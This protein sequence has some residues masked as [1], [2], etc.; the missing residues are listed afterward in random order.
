MAELVTVSATLAIDATEVTRAQY[1]A[2]LATQP[3]LGGQRTACEWNQSYVPDAACM[4]SSSVCQGA[5]CSR[6]PQPC[7]DFCDA[8]AYCE[9]VGKRLCG[10]MGGGPV[11]SEGSAMTDPAES[12]WHNACTSNGVY[13][14]T[15]GE[16]GEGGRCNDFMM[17]PPSTTTWTVA[18]HGTCQSP[19][20]AY[21]GVFD[22][23]GNVGEW[24]DNC[25][26]SVDED[27]ICNPRGSSFGMGAAEQ[28]CGYSLPL[29][30]DAVRATVGFRCCAL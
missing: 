15:Y 20:Q 12:Q 17:A 13:G 11:S 28:N 26:G 10:A 5:D 27:D 29:P 2:W 22:L 16:E 8:A 9:A 24:E 3:L 19:D 7:V 30:R 1:Q 6:H 21:E 18:S 23:I 25:N 14:Y 4:A